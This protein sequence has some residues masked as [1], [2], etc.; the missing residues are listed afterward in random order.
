MH[1]TDTLAKVSSG[2]N[3]DA[4][5]LYALVTI[6]DSVYFAKF[7]TVVHS[8]QAPKL[9]NVTDIE[10][11]T[12]FAMSQNYPNPFNPTTTLE[13]QLASGG[14]VVMIVY[15]SLGQEVKILFDEGKDAGSYYVTWNAENMPSGVYFVR[16]RV[17][18][19]FGKQIFQDA[20]KLMLVK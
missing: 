16:M 9:R 13:F 2:V 11:P 3:P 15:N 20:K 4:N 12:T 18:D 7:N 19:Q 17:S 10:V 6:E 8:G 14:H 5:A 1:F